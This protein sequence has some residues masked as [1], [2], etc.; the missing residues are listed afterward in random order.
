MP[1]GS[2]DSRGTSGLLF[3][4]IPGERSQLES[5]RGFFMSNGLVA[6]DTGAARGAWL[7]CGLGLL[8]HPA[9]PTT[10]LSTFS[11][12][13][14]TCIGRQDSRWTAAIGPLQSERRMWV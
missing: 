12:E 7:R 13:A 6:V 14:V 10:T 8:P 1:T 9:F 5:A 2:P 11:A 3:P 4:P